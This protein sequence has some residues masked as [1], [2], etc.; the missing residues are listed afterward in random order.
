MTESEKVNVRHRKK[1]A[2]QRK[3]GRKAD[4]QAARQT[5]CAVKLERQFNNE[6]EIKQLFTYYTKQ[7]SFSIPFYCK[8]DCSQCSSNILT[9]C[10]SHV[11]SLSKLGSFYSHR[12]FLFV[13]GINVVP[14]AEQRQQTHKQQIHPVVRR[15]VRVA[16]LAYRRTRVGAIAR[17]T[18]LEIEQQRWTLL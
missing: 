5:D 14:M 12:P 7:T 11:Y 1:I 15:N 4:R 3:A 8:T 16:F 18:R 17:R 2:T 6:I 10:L 13:G 9:D